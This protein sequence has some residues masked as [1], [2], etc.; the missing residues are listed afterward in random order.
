MTQVHHA[1]ERITVLLAVAVRLFREG[2][3]LGLGAHD[4]LHVQTTAGPHAEV[5]A[6]ARVLQP[7]L[8]V[9]D[10]S[11]DD[12]LE[13]MRE[14]RTASPLTRILAFAVGDEI[15]TILDYAA[16]GAH[17]FF[18]ANGSLPEL[19]EAIE[20][21][22]EGE[23][24]C[25]PRLAAQL[26]E[27]AV[28]RSASPASPGAAS[29]LTGRERQVFDLLKRGRSN[30]EIA[31]QLHIAEATVKNHVHHLLGKMQVTTRGK[32]AAAHGA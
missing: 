5:L 12:A 21:T 11:L 7:D 30:K 8:I 6:V 32:A 9:V 29:G 23:L 1:R 27:Q 2:L 31:A 18:S 3:A 19:V 16:A 20:R 25:S 24:P 13:L 22:V 10:V 14:L 4:R 28:H 26:L 15:D 17:G